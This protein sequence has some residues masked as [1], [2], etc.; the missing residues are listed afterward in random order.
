MFPFGRI[1]LTTSAAGGGLDTQTV[2]T[3]ADGTAPA[4]DR[5]RGYVVLQIG[6]ISD[7]S[8]NIY[9]GAAISEIYWDEN[10]GDPFYQLSIP[11]AS[12]SGWASITINGTKTLNR[13]DAAYASGVWNWPTADTASTQAFGASGSKPVVFN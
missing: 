11:G 6:S 9:G 1:P 8:S 3:G 2:T 12:N 4:Q 10:F 7:G 13:A 5:R